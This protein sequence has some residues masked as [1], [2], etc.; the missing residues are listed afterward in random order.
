MD[1]R[2][3]MFDTNNLIVM[4]DREGRATTAFR[5]ARVKGLAWTRLTPESIRQLAAE[6]VQK[7]AQFRAVRQLL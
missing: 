7:S 1:P 2:S 6:A 3:E 5:D 4:R